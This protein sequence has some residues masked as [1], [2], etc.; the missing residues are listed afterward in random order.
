MRPSSDAEV[1]A[2]DIVI[3][4]IVENADVKRQI[5]EAVGTA[6]CGPMPF[7]PRT[8]QRF[9]ITQ[10]AGGLEAIR[11]DSVGFTFSIPSAR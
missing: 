7:W 1:A 4:A 6:S 8:P 5:Y 2:A 10:L 11:N 9:P 3:E